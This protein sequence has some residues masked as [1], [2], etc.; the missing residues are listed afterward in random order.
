MSTRP[1]DVTRIEVQDFAELSHLLVERYLR[2]RRGEWVFR[3]HADPEYRLV[4]TIGRARHTSRS[5]EKFE[6]SIFS[7][8]K[9]YAVS[10]LARLP[11]NDFDW[12]CV[13]Q[14][15]GLPTRLLDW[16]F[17]PLAAL[18]FAVIDQPDRGAA[19]WALRATTRISDEDVAT[20]NPL[21][22][23]KSYKFLPG[24]ITPRLHAQEGLFTISSQ[25]QEALEDE[26]RPDWTLEKI[27]LPAL[28]K[29]RV[30]Y[31]LHRQG[32]SVS[33]LFPDLDGLCRQLA[34]QHAVSSDVLAPDAPCAE[35]SA[36]DAPS[37]P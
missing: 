9:R 26:L 8:F 7:M 1:P 18:Y 16:S 5:F 25:P 31:L 21:T 13:A 34:W 36:D 28:C 15:H 29:E 37:E 17:N 22:I 4:P 23:Q 10:H 35:A 33:S 24:S 19:L 3:G 12:L 6:T 32:I 30:R 14:H 11:T 2:F 27:V 20:L